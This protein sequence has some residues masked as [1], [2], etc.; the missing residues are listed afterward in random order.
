MVSKPIALWSKQIMKLQH[1]PL[2][3]FT[4]PFSD[5][6][7]IFRNMR[8]CLKMAKSMSS[9]LHGS[10]LWHSLW[11]CS[12]GS[13]FYLD[14]HHS[15]SYCFVCLDPQTLHRMGTQSQ[16]IWNPVWCVESYL[17]QVWILVTIPQISAMK[18]PVMQSKSCPSEHSHWITACFP[19]CPTLVPPIPL[20]QL[21]LSL[22]CPLS[23]VH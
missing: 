15:Q 6:S 9:F 19:A 2:Q 20:H 21:G 22:I 8:S 1:F 14:A 17:S 7:Y 13:E 5:A 4:T 18:L 12:V 10:R 16:G 3:S 11:L 23:I